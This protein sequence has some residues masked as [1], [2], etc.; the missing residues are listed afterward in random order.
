M[1]N[2]ILLLIVFVVLITT[3]N[4]LDSE[5]KTYKEQVLETSK[6]EEK[7]TLIIKDVVVDKPSKTKLEVEEEFIL[8]PLPENENVETIEV[9]TEEIYLPPLDEKPKVIVDVFEVEK[10]PSEE[11]AELR[12]Q[13]RKSRGNLQLQKTEVV[14]K[15]TNDYLPPIPV[16]EDVSD[17]DEQYLYEGRI[18]SKQEYI[19]LNINE[20]VN[21]KDLVTDENEFSFDNFDN[22]LKDLAPEPIKVKK[23]IKKKASNT[24]DLNDLFN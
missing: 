11:I 2:I 7:K 20:D 1:K 15:K 24:P 3:L 6:N 22:A 16:E 13:L 14:L 12:V 23:V 17:E 8:P 10:S 4:S 9:E 18:I 21:L 5:Q 19:R